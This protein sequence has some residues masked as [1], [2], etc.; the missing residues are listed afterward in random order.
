MPVSASQGSTSGQLCVCMRAHSC[1][2]KCMCVHVYAC[3]CVGVHTYTHMSMC[4]HAAL[5][6]S[7]YLFLLHCF[8]KL[9]HRTDLQEE[10]CIW[11]TISAGSAHGCFF[12]CIMVAKVCHRGELKTQRENTGSMLVSSPPFILL[13]SSLWML[14]GMC[15]E[16][17]SRRICKQQSMQTAI[18]GRQEGIPVQQD[19][20]AAL[21]V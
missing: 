8:D 20:V 5:Y 18:Q 11:F 17:G 2:C 9:S 12:P 15:G 6:M 14:L 3:M 7:V 1:V 21:K 13:F 19:S 16:E 10:R 4:V